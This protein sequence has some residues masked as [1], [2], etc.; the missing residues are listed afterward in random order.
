MKSIYSFFLVGMLL[1]AVP[2]LFSPVW[3]LDDKDPLSGNCGYNANYQAE[4]PNLQWKVDTVKRTLTI[5]GAGRMQDYDELDPKA[6]W[7]VWSKYI[8]KI[9]FPDGMTTVGTYSMYSLWNVK[10]IDWGGSTVTHIYE[11]A[12]Y[13]CKSLT[14]LVLPQSLTYIGLY[15]FAYCSN[16][17]AITMGDRV[18]TISNYA[19]YAPSNLIE[20]DFGNSPA[21][22]GRCAFQGP[23]SLV[24]IKSKR[25]KSIDQYAFEGCEKLVNLQLGD[26]LLVIENYAFKEC[27]SLPE[28]HFPSTIYNFYA[29]SFLNC[30]ALDVI[31][32][33]EKNTTYNSYNNCNAA[34]KTKTNELVLGCW[35]SIVPKS[36]IGIGS[37]A[38][39]ACKRLKSITLPDGLQYIDDYAF[40]SCEVLREISFPSSLIRVEFQSFKDC[41]SLQ[42]VILPEGLQSIDGGAFATCSQLKTV[43]FPESVTSVGCG[44]FFCC[45]NLTEPVYN[46]TW[47]VQ[48]PRSYKGKYNIPASIKNVACQSFYDCDNIEQVNVA[49]SVDKIGRLAFQECNNLIKV[50]LPDNLTYIGDQAF[51]SCNSLSEISIPKRI[52]VIYEETFNRCSSL[53]EI[54]IPD[55]VYEIQRNAFQYCSSL[56]SITFPADLK[57]LYSG[58]LYGCKNLNTII[59]N[60]RQRGAFGTESTS[61]PFYG[62]RDQITS[63]SFGDSVRLVPAGICRNMTALTSVSLGCNIDTIAGAKVF[64]GCKNIQSVHWNLRTCDDP[65]IYY[66]S[67]FYTLRD[68]ITTFTFGDSVRHIPAYLCHSMS[69]LRRLHIPRNVQSIGNFAFRDVNVLDSI[70]ADEKNPYFDSRSHCNALINTSTGELMLGCY[71]TR[72]PQDITSIGDCAFR[73]VLRLKEAALPEGVTYVSTESFNGCHDLKQ[74]SLPQSLT[75]IDAYAFQDC[76]SLSRITLPAGV[77]QIG[78]RAFAHC[79]GMDTVYCQAVTPPDIDETS[80]SDTRCLFVTPCEAVA[81][82]RVA[83]VWGDFG[84]RLLGDYPLTLTVS[85]NDITLGHALILQKPDCEHDAVVDVEPANGCGF[86][87]WQDMQGNVLSRERCY[88]FHMEEDTQVKAVFERVADGVDEAL[89]GDLQI[90]NQTIRFVSGFSGTAAL[91]DMLGNKIDACQVTAGEPA[92]LHAPVTG[93]YVLVVGNESQKIVIR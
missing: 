72:F 89:I 87:E 73:N 91:Y 67:P 52:K 49:A 6:P 55:S 8:D 69:G 90:V 51:T 78:L 4:K 58:L 71:R 54:V 93:V 53:P 84:L 44:V 46:S 38:F 29:S 57:S 88:T 11:R 92:D 21:N 30:W 62:I 33:D 59:W 35:K 34:I 26:S 56:K 48:M 61:D 2:S 39:Y 83:P 79:T 16:I 80:F 25:I 37:Y 7:R 1:F 20:I 70:S 64:E 74:V 27:H 66:N 15:A 75:T 24:T 22:I 85:Q 12:F 9:I 86:V 77:E 68:N 63:F 28:I 14:S 23:H 10:E 19:F 3:A 45:D 41:N 43:K 40:M 76:D 13:Q 65:D 47:F 36:T 31:T 18:K 17:S 50:L 5:T 82:Y 81:D 60:V 42:S 32:V